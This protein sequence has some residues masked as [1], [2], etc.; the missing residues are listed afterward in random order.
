MGICKDNNTTVS[1]AR[2][3]EKLLEKLSKVDFSKAIEETDIKQNNDNIKKKKELE[4]ELNKIEERKKK[5]QIAW[6]EDLIRSNDLK[7][8]MD[9]KREREKEVI[10]QL[11]EFEEIEEVE[12]DRKSVV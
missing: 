1:E 3:E 6:V 7:K 4:Q 2:L 12:L 9:D 10:N 8:R 5:W 11:N